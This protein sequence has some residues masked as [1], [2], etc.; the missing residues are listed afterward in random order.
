MYLVEGKIKPEEPVLEETTDPLLQKAISD[1]L[2]HRVTFRLPVAKAEA[3][4]RPAKMAALRELVAPP[5]PGLAL[6]GAG[7]AGAAAVLAPAPTVR[8]PAEPA[9]PAP[10]ASVKPALAAQASSRVGW[11]SSRWWAVGVPVVVLFVLANVVAFLQLSGKVYPGVRVA[12]VSVGGQTQAAL[13]TTLRQHAAWNMHLTASGQPYELA[14]TD[15]AAA[16]VPRAS[17]QAM[18]IGRSAGLPVIGLIAAW[19]SQPIAMPYQ[20]DD[21]K[22]TKAVATIADMVDRPAH[23][24]AA[25][26]V[27]SQVLGLAELPGVKLNQ[28]DLKASIRAAL[29]E[30]GSVRPN[31]ESVTPL[32]SLSSLQN[33]LQFAQKIIDSP[34]DIAVSKKQTVTVPNTTVA[35]WLRFD[36]SSNNVTLDKG[37]VAS[38]VSSLPGSFDRNLALNDLLASVV[39][40]ETVHYT[41]SG[42]AAPV[43]NPPAVVQRLAVQYSYCV[44]APSAAET[45]QLAAVAEQALTASGGWSLGEQVRFVRQSSDC[46]VRIRLADAAYLKSLAAGC[47]DQATCRVGNEVALLE[48]NWQQGTSTWKAGLTAYQVEM[49]NHEIGHVLGFDHPGCLADSVKPTLS[50]QS[51]TLQSGCSPTWYVVPSSD[52][53]T[54][55]LPGFAG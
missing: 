7:N 1:G 54:T 45:S 13:E 11:L 40:G 15:F 16:D 42:K 20:V 17:R 31:V 39:Q 4:P 19:F 23:D 22:L 55:V 9:K 18:Q 32:V 10:V 3:K 43:Q 26:I 51:I 8:E 29:R 33:S 21:A 12:D 37:S 28:G 2:G 25:V 53:A 5:R 44:K 46:N 27:G 38:Y 30:H 35:G 14:T 47:A 41:V 24:A 48:Q 34:V 52:K 36:S 6:A 49:I 50:S